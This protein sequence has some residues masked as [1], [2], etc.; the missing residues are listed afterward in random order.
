MPADQE[1]AM[2]HCDIYYSNENNE[3]DDTMLS[4]VIRKYF[5]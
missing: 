3:I 5:V 4:T 1:E 2:N